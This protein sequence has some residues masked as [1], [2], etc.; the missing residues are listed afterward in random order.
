M[1]KLTI[2][3][4]KKYAGLVAAFFLS[5]LATE[6]ILAQFIS[7]G[8]ARANV[9][10]TSRRTAR[11]VN[12]RHDYFYGGRY[13]G[14]YYAAPVGAAAAGVATAAVLTSLPGGCSPYHNYYNCNGTY[15][16]PQMQGTEV[17]YILVD[18]DD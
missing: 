12:R 7:N 4:V 14:G 5:L 8:A 6:E 18:A 1:K 2:K 15:Y 3:Q 17:V 16:A 13:G 11:R 10:G 9:R